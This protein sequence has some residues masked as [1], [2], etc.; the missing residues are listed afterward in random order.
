MS[1]CV[2]SLVRLDDE[3]VGCLVVIVTDQVW[4]SASLPT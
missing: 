1:C 4:E 2:G 3:D